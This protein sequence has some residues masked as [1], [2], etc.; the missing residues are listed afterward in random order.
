MSPSTVSGS[1]PRSPATSESP[2]ASWTAGAPVTART[3][4]E[5]PGGRSRPARPS[6][7]GTA[8]CGW[9]TRRRSA[10]TRTVDATPSP[11][12]SVGPRSP[13]SWKGPP[14]P[15]SPCRD[16]ATPPSPSGWS[17][18]P[19]SVTR[20]SPTAVPP[21]SCSPGGMVVR[22]RTATAM[23][24]SVAASSTPP[25]CSPPGPT[26]A[27]VLTPSPS[28]ASATGPTAMTTTAGT[29]TTRTVS[30][31]P[32]QALR[33]PRDSSTPPTSAAAAEER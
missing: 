25:A 7:M 8:P 22:S 20:R 4:E 30:P 32:P 11:T 10:S 17:W 26:W 19:T 6:P 33:P 1:R 18:S 27:R 24:C 23:T 29:A 12:A 31:S 15:P 14:A 5:V 16:R 21:P 28:S 9:T 3:P 13:C 2:G